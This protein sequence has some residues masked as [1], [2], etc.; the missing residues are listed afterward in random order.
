MRSGFRH[1]DQYNF[2]KLVCNLGY[3][4]T[5]TCNSKAV[6]S[7]VEHLVYTEM[8]GGSNPSPPTSLSPDQKL[9]AFP[10]L[11]PDRGRPKASAPPERE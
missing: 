2:L 10:S 3:T 5:L 7:A 8:V 4:T 1:T 9:F 6:S 11:T